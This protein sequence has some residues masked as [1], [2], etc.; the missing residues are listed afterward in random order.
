MGKLNDISIKLKI[1][2]GFGFVCILFGIV[3]I[4]TIRFNNKTI[5]E[6]DKVKVDVLPNT[7]NFI[8][9]KRDMRKQARFR[10]KSMN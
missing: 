2:F 7:L 10:S 3:G 6:L 1:F 9:I 5:D 4:T 8:E